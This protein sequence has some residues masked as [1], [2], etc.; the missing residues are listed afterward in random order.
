[1]TATNAI[2]TTASN[3]GS[4]AS[5][6]K[7]VSALFDRLAVLYPISAREWRNV[8]ALNAAKAAWTRAMLEA[9]AMDGFAIRRGL[10]ALKCDIAGGNKWLPSPYLFASYCVR[11]TPE[12]HGLPGNEAAWVEAQRYFNAG[13]HKWS[14]PA[15]MWAAKS[16]SPLDYASPKKEAYC[17]GLFLEAYAGWVKRVANGETV[18]VAA[19]A[20]KPKTVRADPPAG[21]FDSLRAALA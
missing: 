9:G 16:I 20:D 2:T 7:L 1:M 18:P 12:D 4:E 3:R 10:E 21:F 14:H 8:D 5:A 19:I 11:V 6:S 15:V 13:F 17:K